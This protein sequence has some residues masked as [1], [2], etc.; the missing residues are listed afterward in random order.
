MP[1]STLS[2]LTVASL[3]GLVPSLA[4]AYALFWPGA[5]GLDPY[6]YPVARDFINFWAG[7]R[8]ALSG[9]VAE[10]YHLDAYEAAVHG[11]FAPMQR[12]MNFSYPPHALPLLLPVGALPHP[13]AAALWIA[14]GLFAF[15]VAALG[16]PIPADRRALIVVLLLS[17]AAILNAV[18]GQAGTIFALVFVAGFWLL[19]RR[20][21]G[22][23]VLFGLLTVKPHLGLLIPLALV[24]RRAWLT[25]AAA[26]LTTLALVAFS[27]LFYGVEPWQ[28]FFANTVVY[29]KRVVI[30]MVGFYTTMMYSPYAFFW[31]LGFG[32]AAA[33]TLHIAIALPVA[34]LALAAFR[35]T[36][37]APLATALLA[38]AAVIVPPYSLCYD[39]AIPA[40]ALAHWLV[41]RTAPLNQSTRIALAAFW[42]IPFVTIALTPMGLPVAPLIVLA[43]YACLVRQTRLRAAVAVA[44]ASRPAPA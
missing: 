23:G 31:W 6:G 1:R 5:D 25:I 34:L 39:L 2:T 29:Q 35:R 24:L 41:H 37:D 32:T 19:P 10:I 27:I 18:L 43:M 8:L 26:T 22:A 12:F 20:P 13:L 9:R 44:G 14:A 21:V 28:A 16:W 3:L 42:I 15:V 4:L 40:A 36:T 33:M 30:E 38:L 11:F 7:G 17:P